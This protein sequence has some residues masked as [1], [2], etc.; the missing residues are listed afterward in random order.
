MFY[1]GIEFLHKFKHGDFLQIG[2]LK[3]GGGCLPKHKYYGM[4]NYQLRL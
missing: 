1:I 3:T 4:K 2:G